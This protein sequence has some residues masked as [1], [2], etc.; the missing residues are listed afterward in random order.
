M[1]NRDPLSARSPLD[2]VDTGA[3]LFAPA[4]S[5]LADLATAPDATAIA[6]LVDL[7]AADLS[8][9]DG[10][11]EVVFIDTAIAGY[12]QLIAGIAPGIGI[13]LIAAGADGLAAMAAWGAQNQGYTAVH[14]FSHGAEATLQLGTDL[15]S[16][17]DLAAPVVQGELQA[18]GHALVPGGALLVYACDLAAGTDGQAFI[19]TMAAA[20]GAVVAG[21]T[22]RT[23]S[24]AL[25]GNWVL[26]RSTGDIAVPTLS[27][28]GFAGVMDITNVTA[29]F[30]VAPA[31][32]GVYARA[33]IGLPNN[34]TAVL[35]NANHLKIYSPDGVLIKDIDISSKL[36]SYASNNEIK[37]LAMANGNI[38]I[39]NNKGS[40]SAGG[41][42]NAFFA[43]IDQNGNTIT[44]G[45]IINQTAPSVYWDN[46]I[47][48]F[49]NMGQLSNG[50]IVFEY[51]RTD[52]AT[53]EFRIWST[54]TNSWLTDEAPV[55]AVSEASLA[56]GNDGT[57]MIAYSTTVYSGGHYTQ[58]DTY[59]IYNSG[60]SLIT[61]NDYFQGDYDHNN[62]LQAIANPAGGYL[63]MVQHGNGEVI[64]DF[65]SSAGVMNPTEW[66]NMPGFAAPIY[67]PGAQGF[68]ILTYND[69]VASAGSAFADYNTFI[70]NK[71]PYAHFIATQ[72]AE[73][74]FYNTYGTFVTKTATDAGYVNELYYTTQGG[75]V[76]F[77]YNHSVSPSYQLFSGYSRGAGVVKTD[78]TANNV[79]E[80]LTLQAFDMPGAPTVN[81][82]TCAVGSPVVTH[83][84]TVTFAVAFSMPV[85]GVTAAAFSLSG[86][87]AVGSIGTPSTADGGTTWLVQVSGVSGNGTLRLDLT[88][89]TGIVDGNNVPM[90]GGF[91]GGQSF[92]IDNTAP[93]IANLNGD[94]PGFVIG[95]TAAL[96][97]TGT[98]ASIVEA[99]INAGGTLTASLANVIAGEDLLGLKTTIGGITVATAAGVVTISD[100][101]TAIGSYTSASG[102]AGNPLII[103]LSS[104]D[105]A[106][107]VADLLH[108][109]TYTD[110]NPNATVATRTVNVTLADVV[111]NTSTTAA[112]SITEDIRP[113]LTTTGTAAATQGGAAA[114]IDSGV[115]INAATPHWNGGKLVVQ[116]TGNADAAH[117]TLSLP[118]SN[119]G[120]SGIWLSGTNLMAGATQIGTAS[121]ASVAGGG[122]WTFTFNGTAATADVQAVADAVRLAIAAN[123][124]VVNRTVTYTATDAIGGTAS[125]TDQVS[126]A[127][128]PVTSINL[129]NQE[130]AIANAVT[131][132]GT[133]NITLSGTVALNGTSITSINLHSGVVLNVVG[134]GATLNGA[135]AQ[136]GFVV[137]AGSVS[138]QN[139]TIANMKAQGGNGNGLGGGGAGLG[140]GL[141]VGA[142]T[143]GNVGNVTL[144]NVTF[145]GDAAQ[146]GN[147]SGS[148]S[149]GAGGTD[150]AGSAGNFGAGGSGGSSALF[151]NT[152]GGNGGF[153]GGGGGGYDAALNFGGGGSGGFGAGNGS[154]AYTSGFLGTTWNTGTGGGGLGAGADVFVQQ[155]ASI[156]IAGTSNL[157]AGT[158]AGG[159]GANGGQGLGS[160]IFMQGTNS[161]T[162]APGAGGT[163]IVAGV[164]ADQAG[165][166]GAA[167][168]VVNGAGTLKLTGANTYTGGTTLQAGTLEIASGAAVGSGAI[169][170]TAASSLRLDATLT[171]TSNSFATKLINFGDSETIDLRGL[172]FATG[173]T[174]V[175]TSGTLLTVTSGST[176]EKLTLTT[177]GNSFFKVINDGN[178]GSQVTT[179]PLTVSAALVTDSGASTTD[180]I[181]NNL[182]MTGTVLAGSLVAAGAKVKI[183]DGANVLSTVTANAQG[184]WNYTPTGLAQ[185]AHSL[186]VTALDDAALPTTTLNVTYL[187]TATPV[188]LQLGNAD[189]PDLFR[190]VVVFNSATGGSS[191]YGSLITDASG[192]LFGTTLAGGTNSNGTVF[193]IA[194]QSGVY[195]STATV[196]ANFN[197]SLNGNMPRAGLLIDAS[198]NLFGTTLSGGSGGNGTV[199]ELVNNNGTYA[200]TPTVVYNFPNNRSAGYLPLSGLIADAAGDLFGTAVGGG[201]GQ[202]GTVFEF[203]KT[204]GQYASTPTILAS[205]N[206]SNGAS[207][208]GSLLMDAQGNLFGTAASK[209]LNDVGNVFEIQHSAGGYASTPTIL[210]SFNGANGSSPQAGLIADA[211]GD[212]FGTTQTG[213]SSNAGTVF[214]ILHDA[215]GYASTPTVLVNFNSA[216][217]TSPLGDLYADANGNLFGTTFGGGANG[218]G[219]VFE[220]RK[221]GSSYASTPTVVANFTSANGA[222]PRGGLIADATGVLLGTASAGGPTGAGAVFSLTQ[223]TDSPALTGTAAPNATVSLTEGTVALGTATADA[224]GV[225]S[226]TPTALSAGLHTVV[227]RSTDVAGNVAASTLQFNYTVPAPTVTSITRHVAGALSAA[228]TDSFDVVFS[229]AVTGVTASAFSLATTGSVVGNIGTITGSGSSYTVA[230][231]GVSGS[232]GLRLNQSAAGAVVNASGVALSGTHTADQSYTVDTNAPTVTGVTLDKAAYKLGDTVTATITS[233]ANDFNGDYTLGDGTNIDG[234]KLTGWS[235]NAKSATGTASFI[236]TSASTEVI[237]GA[238]AESIKLVD[239]A[240][241]IGSAYTT[242]LKATTID[243]HAP[244]ALALSAASVASAPNSVVGTLTPTD[245]TTADKFTYALVADATTPANSADN[246]SFVLSGNTLMVG[247]SKLAGGTDHVAVQVTDLGGNSFT[248]TFAITVNAGPSVSSITRAGAALTRAAS[249]SFTV[250]FSA[251]VSGVAATNFSLS[252]TDGTGLIG[253]PTS[254]DGITWTVPVTA[255]SGNGTL[256]LDLTSTSGITAVAGGQ[257]LSAGHTGDQSYTVDTTA[258]VITAVALDKSTYM[259]GDTVTATVTTDAYDGHGAYTLAPGSTVDGMALTGWSYS[260]ASHSGTASF[261]V[262]SASTEVVASQVA[263]SVQVVDAAGNTSAA[264]TAPF[265]NT[266][267]DSHAP[268]ALALSVATVANAAGTVVGTL[269]PTDATANDSF[270][271]ALVTDATTPANSADNSKFVLAGATLSVGGTAIAAGTDHVEI[272]VTD[273]GGNSFTQA[274]N[275]TVL[276]QPVATGIARVGAALTNA[277][278]DRFTVS[279]SVAV[280]GVAASNFS[281]AGTDG[282]GL[283]GTPTSSDGIT[284]AV[285]VTGVSGNGTLGLNLS[286]VTG[287]TAV[288]GG[289]TLA[290]TLVGPLYTVDTTAPVVTTVTLDKSAYK[291]GDTVTATI[292]TDAYDGNGAYTLAPGSTVDGMA[293]TGWSYSTASHSGTASFTVTSASPEMVA[294]LVAV[295]VQVVDAAGNTSAAA[296]APVAST[297]IDT[298]APTALA[299]SSNAT[300]IVANSIVGT[301]SPT[302]ATPN[303]SFT[304][305]L[306]A[307]G[308]ASADNG[309]FVLTSNTLS[310]G[311]SN[312]LAGAEHV[313]VQVTDAGGN[314]FLQDL[315]ITAVT[316]PTVLSISRG[317]AAALTNASSESFTVSFSAAV[318]G[319]AAG[320]FALT[321]SDGTGT[322]GTPTSG[323]GGLTWV[324][325][326]TAVSGNG[327]LGLNLATPAGISAV[328]NGYALSAGRTG[329]EAYIVDTVAPVVTGVTLDNAVYKLGDTVTATIST[330]TYDGYG[331]YTLAAGSSIDGMTLTGWSYNAG[332]STGTAQFVV[333]ASSTEVIAGNV[334][335]AIQVTNAA[336]NT[337][338]AYTTAVAS[339]TIDSHA[340]TALAL[341][342]LRLATAANAVVGTLSPTDATSGDSF[343]YALVADASTP[344][345]SADNASF[346]LTGAMLSVG[347]T[348]LAA[349]TDHVEIQVTD[350]GGNSFTQA[351]SLT[352]VAA[353]TVVAINRGGAALTRAASD[354]FTVSFSAAVTG[355]SA[356]NFAL[357][358]TDGT[359]VVGTPTSSDGVTWTVPVTGVA[360]NGTLA[361]NLTSTSGIALAGGGL[362]LALA[363]THPGDQAYT[364]DTTAPVITGVTLDKSVYKLGD[365]V[366]ASISLS[367]DDGNGAYTLATGSTV[368]GMTLT[369]WS[370]NAGTATGTAS[371]VVTSAS[372]EVMDGAVAS[373][374]Q[375]ADAAGN[376]SAA[377][378]TA[379]ASTTIDSHAPTALALSS[380]RLATAANAVVGTLSPT[381]ATS[382]D[383]FT[384]ALVADAST[385]ANS[386]DN[387][388]FVLTGAMLSVGSTALAA[389]TDHVEIQVT[390]AGGNSFTQAFS[391]TAVAAPTVVAIN[392]GGAALTRAASDSFTVSFSAAV[393]GVSAGNFALAGTD[394]TGVVGTP[395]SSDGVTWT[396]PVTGVA[397]NGTLALNLTST[398]GIALAGGGLALAL[399]GTH[400]GDQAYTVD[401]TAPVI[402]G[403]TLDKSV[404]KLGDTVT[405]SISLSQDDGNGAYTLATGSTVDG[406]TLTGWSYNAATATG[407]AS[408]VVTSASTEVI[409]GAVASHVQVADAAGNISRLASLPIPATTIDSHAPTALSLSAS[410]VGSPAGTL[411]GTLSPTDATP[412]DSFTY[413][414]VA[415]GA[416]SADNASFLLS[417]NT[418]LVGST[419]L[420]AGTAYHVAVQVTDAGGNS[421]IQV[422][423][424]LA[425]SPLPSPV[426]A[427]LTIL[428]DSGTSQT[429]GLTNITAPI[430]MGTAQAGAQLNVFVNAVYVGNTLIDR[431]GNWIYKLP[432]QAQ[433]TQVVTVQCADASGHVSALSAGYAVTIDTSAPAIPVITG[434]SSGSDSGLSA[435]DGITNVT[436]PV[437]TGTAE[438]GS[439][440]AISAGGGVASGSTVADASGHWSFAVTSSF[441]D[442]SYSFTALASDAA[443]NA[444]RSST[445]YGVVID[446]KA[447]MLRMVLAR[448]T[449]S[450]ATDKITSNPT[451]AGTGDAN[452]LV[453][454][455]KGTTV[456]GT[457]TANATGAWSFTP[458]TGLVQG[459]NTLTASETDA[460][461]NTGSSSL[462]FTYD[463]QPATGLVATATAVGVQGSAGL[464]ATTL[465]TL[466]ET[467]GPANDSYSTTLAAGSSAGLALSGAGV[468][469]TTGLAGAAGGAVYT[470]NVA[471]TDTTSGVSAA[472]GPVD[473]VVGSA[474]ADSISLSTLGL[475]ASTPAFIYGLAGADVIDATGMTSSFTFIGG[476]GADTMTGG[477][478][479]NI[480]TYAAATEST[481]SA[482]DIIT[483]FGAQD[484]LDLTAITGLSSPTALGN[485]TT[486]ASR[487]VGWQ[488]SGGNTFVYVNTTGGTATLA[489]AAMKIELLGTPNLTAANFHL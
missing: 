476:A 95:G 265:A 423:T 139:M 133:V 309:K 368:D 445:P 260:T 10:H 284:W 257:A 168:L 357:A 38:L 444:S 114:V 160:G 447:P 42:E 123:G 415:N 9:D 40:T 459:A 141:F 428:T 412:G 461:G 104:G 56:I 212:L 83:G 124:A 422:Y 457:T 6:G 178:G 134:N 327:T 469:S 238:V 311:G 27:V 204:L 352:A 209:G 92:A 113:T 111:G 280:N 18:L 448:D 306:V 59:K 443:G 331:P 115:A 162:L 50:N 242:T 363:G 463:T 36:T 153:G 180:R 408:F 227:A 74:N 310:V 430:V 267:I 195:A 396:V 462:T 276:N 383:S 319:V 274:L 122:A 82:I 72:S 387:A 11:K 471:V 197:A 293:L 407:T 369:G 375:V 87:D 179:V 225:W 241:N 436:T 277:A 191:P 52:N 479:A 231:T 93:V 279:F 261:T 454:L 203:A 148:G 424:L 478:G 268:T 163:E 390:D 281:L 373:H 328:S 449:G 376:T 450:S 484:S 135:N 237:A 323:D 136:A 183:A 278:S 316:G 49:V 403:V 78:Y 440:V 220:I 45:T 470:A 282:T 420:L 329:D 33:Q 429:D 68:A 398:S 339:T 345:N 100:A 434:L 324:V 171:G 94:T 130:I 176:S 200:S 145:S 73:L 487:S 379:V 103:T 291:L 88:S 473:V 219:T 322:I 60:G 367:Q 259:L 477:A 418:L 347:S 333:T 91:T 193:E 340:P 127:M 245:A 15:L 185:G 336:N 468:L 482:M 62:W 211:N 250:S 47:T 313:A 253:T 3:T 314:S 4:I 101:G 382:G 89:I 451:L 22:D 216:T 48:R 184:V 190:D 452:A 161:L 334:A 54:T 96:L 295:S 46:P 344:A 230:V 258:P 55:G 355:V 67:T 24:A 410:T 446:T 252:G 206:G 233:D 384:Y 80:G 108:A 35:T 235:Y 151:A 223:N 143:A 39:E 421:F 256:Q 214:E 98:A 304:Y 240:G 234:M 8:Q 348:A 34:E 351:F 221:I 485:A 5:A 437:L 361:L 271:Y 210:V 159:S 442:G 170:F 125:A 364:V 187:T 458:S 207:P 120:G 218:R 366:T 385:P 386:A 292:T 346:V 441:S 186:T 433:G 356:G 432:T 85:T 177:P 181:T 489:A 173:A 156:T 13:E 217:G 419:G 378:T 392:R 325:P 402:T 147:G 90:L 275:I 65:V 296:T 21:S 76:S 112:I 395:T 19:K 43:I 254:S 239:A 152:T 389:G 232:G 362:A 299:L 154:G 128:A 289:Q 326:V 399:A 164:I 286:S 381:D 300:S 359:G 335:T 25:G 44:P 427:G 192:N 174:A 488:T 358:G 467:G 409:A 157:G 288:A 53:T 342:S 226:F 425:A 380:L 37:L 475:A 2:V 116:I 377:Y 131:S 194:N 411:V 263:A 169:T 397:G 12:Q 435:S 460:A 198:G 51:Q 118:G 75:G 406:M 31:A 372:T 374:L 201:P 290:G 222:N 483:N 283:I 70:A 353:P 167:S 61:A 320:N 317:G 213:G 439:T 456:L 71:T 481:A 307:D 416:A 466:T 14:V 1:Q 371:F 305:A 117:D 58:H 137:Q 126:V 270:T 360:G 228:S 41:S 17:A 332:T 189:L 119:P 166:G 64:G 269:L 264:Y 66:R 301:L 106:T 202:N 455:T 138:F 86:T 244:T 144:T 182:A 32:A 321:G 188:S 132:P 302:D 81:G 298:H 99:N 69:A 393:T 337:S 486:L 165:A 315:T 400:P 426:I 417:G 246:A 155:G 480:Y 150:N 199:F 472:L 287:I 158:V 140:G 312:L 129:L 349:G 249:D 109:L 303:D 431:N 84:G 149:T 388:S 215:G 142:D 318:A 172:T 63:V 404:Y 414:L 205:F 224:N 77:D 97:D 394:G 229:S 110:T 297:T 7:R 405:A 266:T 413:A 294:G 474:G 26:E 105:T 308:A 175:L 338:A 28:S 272:Q 401:T 30:T 350:A 255:V 102:S 464:N 196:L 262:T 57:F 438:A 354:S 370:Y 330:S 243:T 453:T 247:G 285:P 121:A 107:Q 341:S 365:T 236:V 20:T 23:G 273:A 79:S 343:T 16:A 391:L 251:A 208:S 248:Q 465:G 29:D 146:G